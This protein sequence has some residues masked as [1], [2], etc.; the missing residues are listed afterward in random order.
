MQ[1]TTLVP[2]V[3]YRC[4]SKHQQLPSDPGSRTLSPPEC[5]G[6]VGCSLHLSRSAGG[7]GA[8]F[9]RCPGEL[10]WGLRCAQHPTPP[11]ILTLEAAKRLDKMD[12]ATW[13]IK[14]SKVCNE[15]ST[16]PMSIWIRI[17]FSKK[18]IKCSESIHIPDVGRVPPRKNHVISHI[19]EAINQSASN[20]INQCWACDS[21]MSPPGSELHRSWK[22]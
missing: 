16:F 11:P 22:K 7:S 15:F 12:K 4:C 14:R 10:F 20:V 19:P 2:L 6:M 8:D 17:G 1:G 13:Q 3:P 21:H 18:N 9:G 5:R